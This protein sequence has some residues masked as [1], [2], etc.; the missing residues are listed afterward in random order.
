MYRT[1]VTNRRRPHVFTVAVA[2]ARI[3]S[4]SSTGFSVHYRRILLVILS[5][6]CTYVIANVCSLQAV[7]DDAALNDAL[8]LLFFAFIQ[9]TAAFTPLWLSIITHQ[10]TFSTSKYIY[11][12]CNGIYMHHDQR[13]IQPRQ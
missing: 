9:P 11:L 12:V 6:L 4:L 1:I 10:A 3:D 8:V 13:G 2:I 5:L 7:A